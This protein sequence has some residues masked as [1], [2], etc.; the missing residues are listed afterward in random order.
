MKRSVFNASLCVAILSLVVFCACGG[1]A[2]VKVT[3][4]TPGA[5]AIDQGQ[6]VNLT[7]T[8]AND[9]M[10]K[11]VT[12]ALTGPG[13][14]SNVTATSVTYT[15][16][17]VGTVPAP[18]LTTGAAMVTATSVADPTKSGTTTINVSAVP[19]ITT[20]S[21][22]PDGTE[23]TAY[24]HTISASGGAGTLTFSLTAGT[25]PAGLALGGNGAITGTPTGPDG[26]SNFTVKVTDSSAAGAQSASQPFSIKINLPQAPT[27]T[28]AALAAGTEGTAYNQ[29]VM[30]TAGTGLAPFTWTPTGTL[31]AGL[32]GVA[33]A[34][35]VSFTI[36]GTP[37]GPSGTTPYSLQVKDSSNPQQ[38]ATQNYNITINL[39]PPPTIT[40][41]SLPAGVEGT[42]YSQPVQATGGLTPYTFSISAGSLP[43]GLTINASTGVISGTPTGPNG[44]ANF[45]VMVTDSSKDAS[46]QPQS[47]TKALSILINLP[48]PP[49]IAP[50]G[51]TLTG[52]IGTAFSQTF[53]VSGGLGPTF[54]WLLT[55]TL[56]AGLTGTQTG[57]S[58]QITGTPTGP[59]GDSNVTLKVTDSSNPAQNDTQNYTITINNPPPP[60]ITTTQAQIPS[61][62]VGAPYSFQFQ[63]SGFGTL[64][65]SA[66]GLPAD[67]LSMSTSGLVTGTPSTAQTVN[68]S[69]TVTDSLG[70]SSA[71]T[72]FSILVS[73]ISIAFTPSAP[74]SVTAG[75]TLGVTATVTN[76]PG[77]GGVDWTVSCPD[78]GCGSFNPTHTAS[79]AQTTYT[80]PPGVP[81][82]GTVTI[83]AT[84][85]D[86]PSPQVSAVVTVNP[87]PVQ[88]VFTLS[89]PSSLAV[90]GTANVS[91]TVSNDPGNAGVD[92][93]VTCGSVDC[94]SFTS[95]H[96]TSGAQTTYTAPAS[97]PTGGSVTIQATATSNPMPL[98]SA[99][100]TITSGALPTCPL[101]PGGN[102][103]LLSGTYAILFNGWN[104]MTGTPPAPAMS[105]AAG[106]FTAD[107]TGM[108]SSVVADPNGVGQTSSTQTGTGC[109]SV[110]PDRRGTMIFSFP[111]GEGVVFSIAVR[112]N[113]NGGRVIEFDDTTGNSGGRG[114][115]QFKKQTT[116]DFSTF[117]LN[118]SFAVGVRGAAADNNRSGVV[119]AITGNSAGTI[120]S[121][122][123]DI[124]FVN[125]GTAN[126]IPDTSASVTGTYTTPD[127]THGRGTITLTVTVSPP[128]SVVLTLHFAYYVIDSTQM[129]IQS[130]DTPDTAGHA[131]LN[132]LMGK[133][134]GAFSNA[135]L[136]SSAIFS[137][138]GAD[139]STSHAFTDT[140][141]GLI[142]SPGDGTFTGV[143]DQ[144]V[145]GVVTDNQAIS[146]T[147]SIAA[148]GLGKLTVTS[149]AGIAPFTVVMIAPNTALMLGGTLAS[150]NNDIP[151]GIL[152]AQTGG[153]SFTGISINGTLVL[154]TD[155]PA[156]T[157]VEVELGE[158][159]I[160]NPDF[161]ITED[162]SSQGGLQHDQMMS[163]TY[164][165]APNGRGVITIPGP[166]G[167]TAI[168]WF[169]QTGKAVVLVQTD[170]ISA[171]ID[172][173]Q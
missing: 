120:T 172:L 105:Q 156:T 139:P 51:K 170:P 164:T 102:E 173:D 84:A 94:G 98:V 111:G 131:L 89:P 25:L 27:I 115:G 118:G 33:S 127:T 60:T 171:I 91:A 74:S 18:A 90:N 38:S 5:V 123:A 152:Q 116:A 8:I 103:G 59:S 126:F 132:G 169:I 19:A 81:T 130:T 155:E 77:A 62:A 85:T 165:M 168:M 26:T 28:P 166:H 96:T 73:T 23:G 61:A 45:T 20:T 117:T 125:S 142:T 112:S 35:G 92:W 16:P 1:A 57:T 7:A 161:T 67:N 53:T 133:Q 29:V 151:T 64:T 70:Q 140:A 163:G 10:N 100:V 119:A 148:N 41:A 52:T 167:G 44:T 138:T 99:Q 135:S 121:G 107:G 82:G 9:S 39:P 22:L 66:T 143:L 40:T 97:V 55:G 80:A 2:A 150:P 124:E 31:P 3:L 71:A 72:P 34:G 75:G 24:N 146:G 153:G 43:A 145:N 114:S 141:I 11:G 76:D 136:N 104:D 37:T 128:I 50:A 110:G 162:R 87:P 159:V 30:V 36:S 109:Y 149:P 63:G 137:L 147:V 12:W 4:S 108:V 6:S 14:L 154:G 32:T 122:A 144:N 13:A 65:W 78:V 83:T 101:A 49:V 56:P 88:I 113:G 106:S 46:S 160:S 15:A 86:A 158:L 129:Y 69:V 68:F 157:D 95:A 47:G 42:A 134:S 58:F 93:T 54:T 21:P 79:G 48:P 17:A